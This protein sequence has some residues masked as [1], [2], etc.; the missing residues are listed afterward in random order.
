MI[1]RIE[2]RLGRPSWVLLQTGAIIT[3]LLAGVTLGSRAISAGA[4]GRG[5][6]LVLLLLL[7]V[8]SSAVAMARIELGILLLTGVAVA[9]PITVGTG[10]SSPLVASLLCAFWIVAIWLAHMLATG[11]VKLAHSFVNLPLLGFTLAAVLATINSNA[12][13]NPLVSVPPTWSLIQAG[14]I[15]VFVASAGVFL[16]A[17]NSLTR[18]RHVRLLVWVFIGLGTLAIAGYLARSGQDLPGFATGGL[19]SLWVIVLAAGQALFNASLSTR[20]R[21]ALLVI[22]GAW[23]FRRFFLE[24][25]WLSG[26]L[27]AVVAIL[28]L[29]LLK[30][31]KAFLL[32]VLIALVAGISRY[33]E[34]LATQVVGADSAGNILRLDL[35]QQ[36]L[37]LTRDHLLLGTGIAGYAAYYMTFFPDHALSTHSNYLDVFAQTG[38]IG[39]FFFLWLLVALF[40][41]GFQ[42]RR[43]WRAGFGSGFANAMLAGLVGLVVAMALGDWFIPFVYNQTIAGFR[44]TVHSW[45]LLGALASMMHI[46]VP[47]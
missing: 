32:V 9:V 31:R 36:N 3:L 2:R 5:V 45:L 39:S 18:L 24:L 10:T 23:L 20:M 14:G 33:D 41:T 26:W 4:G 12:D 30:S 16:V 47:E 40:R 29:S 42:A 13:R 7:G 34:I 25:G 22:A 21:V 15:S 44:Y 11:S 8:A 17:V 35:W 38:L 37:A 27:P 19:F 46:E 6:S 1:G 43:R 28:I